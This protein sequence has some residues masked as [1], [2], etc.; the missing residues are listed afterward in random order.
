MARAVVIE[1]FGGPEVLTLSEVERPQP[2]PG[3]M[4]VRVM[5]SGTNPVE[6]KIRQGKAIPALPLPA[7]LG[8]DVSG[9]VESVGAGV[10]DLTPGDEVYYTPE[11]NSRAGSYADYNVA[12][13]DIVALKPHNLSHTEAV[14]IPL[15]GGTAWEAIVRRLAVRP[16]ETV[17]I[18]AGAGG[19]GSFAVQFA[20]AAGAQVL[21]TVGTDDQ[22]LLT[23]LGATAIDYTTQDVVDAALDHTDGSGVD[24]VLDLVGGEN[25]VTSATATRPFG[26]IATVLAPPPASSPRST[27]ATSNCTASCSPANAAASTRCGPCSNAARCVP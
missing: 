25:L 11:M 3:Q 1:E 13:A 22:Q 15:A 24:A 18:H 27:S 19:V 20:V 6:A 17:L 2:G 14:A 8:G 26:R 10:T 9:V 16:G 7:V 5:A 4:L 12:A 21:A 23:D